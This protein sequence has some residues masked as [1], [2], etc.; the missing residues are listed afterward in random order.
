MKIK[1]FQFLSLTILFI[2]AITKV[3]AQDRIHELEA[4]M[5]RW[6][7]DNPALLESVDISVSEVSIQEF[8]RGIARN[9]HLNITVDPALQFIV[10]NNFSDVRV[11]DILLHLCKEYELDITSTGNILS[12]QKYIP[13]KVEAPVKEVKQLIIYNKERDLLTLDVEKDTLSEIVH[14]I[15]D[16][17]GKNIVM[18]AGISQKQVEGYIKEMP[19]DNSLE[20]FAFANSLEVN[21]TADNFYI[22]SEKNSKASQGIS[23]VPDNKNKL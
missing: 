5:E 2:S 20:K 22:L 18:E 17:S 23:T 10:V 3:T 11:M 9:V 13:P 14:L 21:K 7:K 12:V 1:L 4:R 6:S 16:K 15:T 19:F 8:L